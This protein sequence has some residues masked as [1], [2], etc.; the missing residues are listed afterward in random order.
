M[1]TIQIA[2]LQDRE[3]MLKKTVESLRPQCDKIFVALNGYR[4]VP[5][6]LKEDEYVMLD[7]SR[8]DAAKFYNIER[9]EGYILTCD[10]DLIYPADY[11]QYMKIGVDKY[12]CPCTLHG[13]TYNIP[14]KAFNIT[15]ANFQ[16]LNDVFGDGRVDI[17]GTGVM[18]WHSSQIKIS[19]SQFGSKNMSDIWFAKI[20]KE[21]GVKIM[22]LEHFKGQLVYQGP[23][24]T[25]WQQEK[26]KGFVEQTKLLKTFIK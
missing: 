12:G 2:S 26:S 14:V 22:C 25:I 9:L 18:C 10:D 19:Y 16:C 6:F 4:A 11:V 3:Q 24:D 17:G 21:Q 13:K 15:R 1:I 20:C 7:N 8:G 5:E 23:K